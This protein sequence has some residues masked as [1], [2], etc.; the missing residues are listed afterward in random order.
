MSVMVLITMPLKAAMAVGLVV[1]TTIVLMISSKASG[2]IRDQRNILDI[3]IPISVI[4][5]MALMIMSM[6]PVVAVFRIR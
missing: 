6:M 1:L 3:D 4:F 5:M 2:H